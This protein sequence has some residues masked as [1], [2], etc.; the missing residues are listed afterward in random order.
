MVNEKNIQTQGFLDDFFLIFIFCC[1]FYLSF[2]P[3]NSPLA[4]PKFYPNDIAKVNKIS[5]LQC[6]TKH[7]AKPIQATDS[8][9][10]ITF[11]IEK[12]FHPIVADFHNLD[13]S[14]YRELKNPLRLFLDT[15]FSYELNQN[16]SSETYSQ[17]LDYH[18]FKHFKKAEG[19]Q[20]FAFLNSFLV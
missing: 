17:P 3:A 2:N 12:Y 19:W 10:I 13:A 8:Q 15:F 16:S 9:T 4:L 1:S 7:S 11:R 14:K 18:T 20:V 6:Q 5:F